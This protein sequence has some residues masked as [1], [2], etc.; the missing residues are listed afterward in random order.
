MSELHL[1]PCCYLNGKYCSYDSAFVDGYFLGF[2]TMLFI[3][4][5]IGVINDIN[6]RYKYNED[7][8]KDEPKNDS[9]KASEEEEEK[10]E[11][12]SDEDKKDE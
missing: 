11:E 2:V 10:Q 7:E 5:L 3:M 4:S 6:D 9:E 1:I 12:K 8:D